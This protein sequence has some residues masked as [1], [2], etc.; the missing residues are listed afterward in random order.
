MNKKMRAAVMTDIMETK[1][2]EKEIP[3]PGRDEVLVKLEYVGVCGSDLHFYENGCIGD[4]K[5]SFPF[6]LGHEPAGEVV[7][8]GEKV[9]GLQAGDKV[10]LEPGKTCGHCELWRNG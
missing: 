2:I 5:V 6:V 10:A 1:I 8:V 7:E 4:T 3:K 9:K